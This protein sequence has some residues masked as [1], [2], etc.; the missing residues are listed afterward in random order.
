[1]ADVKNLAKVI[2]MFQ[3]AAAPISK[4]MK[5]SVVDDAEL[6]FKKELDRINDRRKQSGSFELT[7][8]QF[9]E[10]QLTK[11]PPKEKMVGN[12]GLLPIKEE[13]IP[14]VGKER[15]ILF[16]PDLSG[17]VDYKRIKPK[18]SVSAIAPLAAAEDLYS[19]LQESPIGQAATQWNKLKKM[20]ADK[21]ARALDLTGGKDA[22]FQK[23]ASSVLSTVV[24]PLNAVP[25]APGLI[26]G[27]ATLL[28]KDPEELKKNKKK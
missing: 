20:V 17:Q 11:I 19:E 10:Y 22:Q 24:D 8:D 1:M 27:T 12:K 3:D 26:V 5:T 2:N 16:D 7:P 14:V 6:A 25:G 9:R 28:G 4:K 18:G 15:D 21:T 13:P 23:D